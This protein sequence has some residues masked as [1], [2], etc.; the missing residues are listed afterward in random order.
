MFRLW[1]WGMRHPHLYTLGA[2][3]A[4]WGQVLLARQGW[5]RKIPMFPASQWTKGRDFPALVPKAFRDRWK[6]LRSE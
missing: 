1:A 3:L 4:R 2:R 5:I 6:Q